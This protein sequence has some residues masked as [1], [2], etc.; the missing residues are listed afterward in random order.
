MFETM[1]ALVKKNLDNA[2]TK[3]KSTAEKRMNLARI[4]AGKCPLSLSDANKLRDWAVGYAR[5]WK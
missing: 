1:K 2:F 5:D 3:K 4:M